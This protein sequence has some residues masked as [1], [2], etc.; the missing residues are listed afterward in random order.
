MVEEFAKENSLRQVSISQLQSYHRAKSPSV[1]VKG[2]AALPTRHGNFRAVAFQESVTGLDHLALVYGDVPSDTAVLA[3]IHSEC[4]TGDAL[5]SLRCDCGFQL[6]HALKMIVSEGNGILIYL[7]GQEGRGIGLANKISAYELQDAG[8]DTVDANVALGLP[9]D[10]RSYATAAEILRTLDVNRV[11]L[12][13]NNFHKA[14]DL[15]R[16]GVDVAQR[17]PTT[18]EVT[19]HNSR[20]LFA[21]RDR[22]GHALDVSWI[23]TAADC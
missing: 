21:K 20:Y 18:A 15:Q 9:V 16:N 8:L 19:S 6:E 7:R 22:M 23:E 11:R 14:N 2:S 3:R 1:E 10:D 4:L 17:I 5:G 12:I 13:T